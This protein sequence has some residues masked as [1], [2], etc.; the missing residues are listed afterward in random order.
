L[1]S[2]LYYIL[3][4]LF[5]VNSILFLGTKIF[6]EY[7]KIKTSINA[8]NYSYEDH[9]SGK[10]NREAFHLARKELFYAHKKRT[11]KDT[12]RLKKNRSIQKDDK[13]DEQFERR[14]LDFHEEACAKFE[15]TKPIQF[16]DWWYPNYWL[17]FISMAKP[18]GDKAAKVFYNKPIN[19][20]SADAVSELIQRVAALSDRANRHLA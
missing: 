8:A 3:L 17:V 14:K 10:S 4:D 6:E 15:S 20:L 19:G 12:F 7:Q 9:V 11:F 13:N 16:D 5:Y 18:A 2:S 1:V